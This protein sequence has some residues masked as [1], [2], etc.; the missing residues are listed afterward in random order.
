MEILVRNGLDLCYHR[1]TE[2]YNYI[3]AAVHANNPKL[4]DLFV[5]FE[6]DNFPSILLESD[7]QVSIIQAINKDLREVVKIFIQYEVNHYELGY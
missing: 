3:L 4:T 2:P 6:G 1:N 7:K 5:R